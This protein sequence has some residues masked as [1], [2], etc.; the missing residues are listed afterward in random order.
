MTVAKLLRAGARGARASTFGVAFPRLRL[1]V[2]VGLS[3]SL[4]VCAA[5][6][7][8]VA[9]AAI[10]TLPP[11]PAYMPLDDAIAPSDASYKAPPLSRGVIAE[12]PNPFRDDSADDAAV[13]RTTTST[14][15]GGAGEAKDDADGSMPL[16][17]PSAAAAGDAAA[18]ISALEGPPV[19]LPPL[20]RLS[21]A[22]RTAADALLAADDKPIS[23]NFQ[24]AELGAV[25]N[26]FA[27]FTG[28]NIVASEKVRG[29]VSLRLDKVP[30]RVAF[31]TLLDV[32]GLAMER[33]G[34]VV[35]VAP[36]ADLAARERQRFE[37]HARAAD[38]EPLASRTFQLHYARAEDVRRL[39]TGSGNQRVL[40]KRGAV[41]ADP[42][43]NL[44]FVTD[45]EGRL[46]QIS[47]LLDSV[48]RPTR[49][50]LIEARIVEGEH[51]FS[52]NLGVRLSMA[53]TNTDGNTRGLSGGKDGLV[54]DLSARPIAGFDAATAGLTLFAAGATRLLNIELSALEAEGRGE[55][56]SSPRVVTA[57]RM[58]A[59]VEQ[60]TELPYQAKVG[61]GVSGVQFRRATLKLEVEPQ[62]MPDGR[63][64]LDLDVAK[65][66][67]GEQTDAGPAINTK[68]VQTR[69]EVEDG[70]TVSIG[71]IYATDGRDDV[72]RVPVLGKIPFLGA[73]FRHRAHRDQR[74]EL[75]VFITPR[76]VQTN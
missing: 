28:L 23:L 73:L 46:A 29:A 37:A 39:L 43:T 40:S 35:W 59:V 4:Y 33:H 54:Y 52:R 58:K 13:S 30:W 31:D 34:N 67:V 47:A 61:Q 62:I 44:L 7:A 18:T 1:C 14:G 21:G 27:Q 48:D 51:G 60:G 6:N 5:L 76:V 64:V 9:R 63:V 70:G 26:A 69:V 71:G 16:G 68:H 36:I 41:T 19:P 65:D 66:S 12:T 56:V 75:A 57:D 8:N 53:G 45:L 72:T 38:L 15:Q 11:L 74:S 42:R 32:N 10:P 2:G 55:I 22:P 50:V 20:T 3:M 24:R 25:L 49:Q 17:R